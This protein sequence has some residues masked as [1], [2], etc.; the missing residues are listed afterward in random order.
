MILFAKRVV[1]LARVTEPRA[2]ITRES[3]RYM[4][5]A[6]L[7]KYGVIGIE[8]NL[9]TPYNHSPDTRVA[10]L[11]FAASAVNMSFSPVNM[12]FAILCLPYQFTPF[13]TL[14]SYFSDFFF[15]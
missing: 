3:L 10:T 2:L 14:S 4:H 15:N 1:S 6:R 12:S 11:K 13:W 8:N 9:S 5:I 7:K